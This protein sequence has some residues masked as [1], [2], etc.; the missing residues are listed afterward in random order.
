MTPLTLIANSSRV[1]SK[2]FTSSGCGACGYTHNDVMRLFLYR[3]VFSSEKGRVTL[4]NINRPMG[5]LK[6]L[7]T[8]KYYILECYFAKKYFENFVSSFNEFYFG[9]AH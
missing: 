6:I 7:M 1:L 5:F 3:A 9:W 8:G 4:V 2:A